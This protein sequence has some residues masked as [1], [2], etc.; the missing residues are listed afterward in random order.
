MKQVNYK[1]LDPEDLHTCQHCKHTYHDISIHQNVC[2][3]YGQSITPMDYISVND[4]KEYKSP[5]IK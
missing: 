3:K 4:C 5:Y 2:A 1:G